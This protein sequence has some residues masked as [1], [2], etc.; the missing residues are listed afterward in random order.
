MQFSYK[1]LRY[2]P[3][4]TS[5]AYTSLRIE[6]IEHSTLHRNCF[7]FKLITLFFFFYK[8]RTLDFKKKKKREKKEGKGKIGNF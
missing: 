5:T 4:L 6:I 7:D 1:T 8:Q 3:V 2:N